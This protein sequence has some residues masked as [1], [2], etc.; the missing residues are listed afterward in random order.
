MSKVQASPDLA[1]IEDKDVKKYVSL[2][3][4][5]IVD[6]V[7]GKLELGVNVSGKILSAIFTA[8][9]TDTVFAHG[10]GRVPVGYIRVSASASMVIYN[11][12]SANTSTNLILR[13]SATG[14]AGV[15]VF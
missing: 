5:D 10:L 8:A 1:T 12:S 14:T 4:N 9:N 15:Y 13:S 2:A 6:K 7:N 3:L 11:G